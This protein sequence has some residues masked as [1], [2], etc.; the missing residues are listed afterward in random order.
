MLEGLVVQHIGI[1][2]QGGSPCL[3][4]PWGWLRQI[5]SKTINNWFLTVIYFGAFAPSLVTLMG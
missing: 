1:G 2:K 4:R 5:L 3:V